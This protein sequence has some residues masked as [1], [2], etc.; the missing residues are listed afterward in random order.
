MIDR[1][2]QAGDE[3]R[4]RLAIHMQRFRERR[5]SRASSRVTLVFAVMMAVVLLGLLVF[6]KR[7]GALVWNAFDSVG[8]KP[9]PGG[10]G[11][12]SGQP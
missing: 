4:E 5:R 8:G 6:Q 1:G 11:P 3:E 2:Q 12:T 9:S 10:G 7:C